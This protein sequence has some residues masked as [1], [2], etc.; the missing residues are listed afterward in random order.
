MPDTCLLDLR[1]LRD[2]LASTCHGYCSRKDPLQTN[3]GS[4]TFHYW[5]FVRKECVSQVEFWCDNTMETFVS[6]LHPQRHFHNEKV[7]SFQQNVEKHCLGRWKYCNWLFRVACAVVFG[8]SNVL[9]I[10]SYIFP[11]VLQCYIWEH[12][13]PSINTFQTRFVMAVTQ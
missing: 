2:T 3:E 1:N 13:K 11:F 5:A 7:L 4:D 9:E 6:S 12:V 8:I 10:L